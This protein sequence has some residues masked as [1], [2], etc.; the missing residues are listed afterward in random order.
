[1]GVKDEEHALYQ[2]P[3]H[4]WRRPAAD[5]PLSNLLFAVAT[6]AALVELAAA[7][8]ESVLFGGV[9]LATARAFAVVGIVALLFGNFK[10]IILPLKER[11]TETLQGALE[12]LLRSLWSA[13]FW[14]NPLGVFSLGLFLLF[15][16]RPQ[17]PFYFVA[18]GVLLWQML[19]GLLARDALP[20]ARRQPD[21]GRIAR[22]THRQPAIFVLVAFLVIA[23]FVDSLF[24]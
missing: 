12:P 18:Y 13:H 20:I 2:G 22:A 6:A 1:M 24:P 7:L 14:L 16:P 23:G 8:L 5:R 17:S 4:E 3:P 10:S 15:T 19:A 9:R 11:G 21:I